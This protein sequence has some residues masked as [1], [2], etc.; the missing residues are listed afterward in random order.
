VTATTPA[1]DAPPSGGAAERLAVAVSTVAGIGRV[2][3]APGTFGSLPGV[4]LGF[5]LWHWA[6]PWA[7]VAG[8]VVTSAAGWWSAGVTARALGRDD[9]QIVVI[10]EVAGQLLALLFLTPTPTTLVLGFVLFRLFDITKPFP[11]RRLEKLHGASGIM[12]DDLVAGLYA[13][14]VQRA[15]L[16]GLPDGW[17]A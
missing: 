11:A 12:A 16:Q 10:D 8:L 15:L 17:T 9:P 1:P 5:A 2:P 7:V 13:N 4:A 14:L 3:F 6:G